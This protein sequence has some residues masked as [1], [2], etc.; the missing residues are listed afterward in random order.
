MASYF[1]L[2]GGYIGK[3]RAGQVQI[4]KCY[5]KQQLLLLFYFDT[6]GIYYRL[7]VMWWLNFILFNWCKFSFSFVLTRYHNNHNEKQS[8][9]IL[10]NMKPGLG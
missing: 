3:A 5:P 6:H 7:R 1:F 4:R 9:V 10:I 8:K 2:P